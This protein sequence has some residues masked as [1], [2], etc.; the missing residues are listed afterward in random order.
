MNYVGN[1]WGASGR[2]RMDQTGNQIQGYWELRTA[3]R[4]N[5][6]RPLGPRYVDPES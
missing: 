4:N 6:D 3:G 5:T 2:P 1:T